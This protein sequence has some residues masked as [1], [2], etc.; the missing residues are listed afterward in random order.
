MSQLSE[1]E[2]LSLKRLEIAIL[3][4]RWS[5]EALVK[6]IK[7]AGEYINIMSVSEYAKKNNISYPG[8][9]KNAATRKN[10]ELFNTKF[11]IHV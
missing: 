10:I 9:R 5:D 1:Y 6:L 11:I 7:L 2:Q 3:E 4:D 8:A